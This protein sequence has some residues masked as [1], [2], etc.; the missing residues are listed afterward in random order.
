[1]TPSRRDLA[2]L[3]LGAPLVWA[4]ADAARALGPS[5]LVI[6]RGGAI[7]DFPAGGQGA[8]E[9]AIHDGADFIA[10][11]LAVSKDGSLV[12]LHDHELSTATDVAARPEFAERRRNLVV[13]GADRSGWFAEDFTLAELKSLTLGAPGAKRRPRAGQDSGRSILTF[14]EI[15]AI[16]RAGSVRSAR[17]VGVHATMLHTAYF[18]GL[19]LAIEP[20]LAS[21]IR[22]GGYNSPAAAMFVASAE[23]E[24]LATIGHLIRARRV[25]RLEA[26]GPSRT[27]A[28]IR[29]MAEAVAAPPDAL[30]DLG[31]PKT[32]PTTP[33]I[34]AAHGTGL[35]VQAWTGDGATFPPPPF[36]P[37]DARRLLG[38]LYSAHADAVAGDL[39]GPIARAR[40]EAFP[41]DRD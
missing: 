18:A 9:A 4:V 35:A 16:A 10:A 31:S 3:I 12:A 2:S 40:D 37:G 20:R 41:R 23:T 29:A 28:S 24:A 27:M 1:M 13:D 36:R 6:A 17:V 38:A 30:L 19:D 11:N 7:G 25:L 21:A 8:Y 26:A 15:I 39:A 5:P 34:E 33:F 14:E 32:T 22:V